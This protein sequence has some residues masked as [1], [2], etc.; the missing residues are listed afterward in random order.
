MLVSGLYSQKRC[1]SPALGVFVLFWREGGTAGGMGCQPHSVTSSTADGVNKTTTINTTVYCVYCAY[2]DWLIPQTMAT[3][4]ISLET[5]A[6]KS[7]TLEYVKGSHKW[8]LSL[9]K[10]KFHAPNDYKKYLNDFAE[11]N[12]KIVD[13]EYVKYQL[14]GLLFIME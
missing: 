2:D 1:F 13:I 4:W 3:C 8:E 5:A 11:K 10:G 9:P 12:N 7:G 6:K 14:V